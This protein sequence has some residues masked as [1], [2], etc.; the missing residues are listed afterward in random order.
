[1]FLNLIYGDVEYSN[2]IS[3]ERYPLPPTGVLDMTLNN[4]MVKYLFIAFTPRST[5]T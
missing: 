3:A 2:C 4:L 5:L 1:M